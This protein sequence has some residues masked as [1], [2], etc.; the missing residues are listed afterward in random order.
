VKIEYYH[1]PKK[2]TYALMFASDA[3][4]SIPRNWDRIDELYRPLLSEYEPDLWEIPA[5]QILAYL[6]NNNYHTTNME[7]LGRTGTMKILT[8]EMYRTI[9]ANQDTR[10]GICNEGIEELRQGMLARSTDPKVTMEILNMTPMKILET[11]LRE[12]MDYVQVQ[13]VLNQPDG[14]FVE[15]T[16]F[17]K[18]TL[19]MVKH[20]RR[21]MKQAQHIK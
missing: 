2:R 16:D 10:N 7:Y 19:S 20:E 3:D 15:F 4:V 17:E 18:L 1:V 12:K 5:E 8:E 14:Y 13:S 21:A 9:V 6:K 11:L